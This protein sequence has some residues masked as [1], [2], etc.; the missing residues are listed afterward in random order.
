VTSGAA[1]EATK[2]IRALRAAHL[3]DEGRHALLQMTCE[4]IRSWGPPYTSVYAYMLDGAELVLE[5]HAGRETEHTR[6]PVGRGVCGTAV[7]EQRDQNVADVS[8]IGNYLACNLF[9]KSELVVLIRRGDHI[10]GQIDIDSDVPSGFGEREH[11]EVKEV[12]DALAVLL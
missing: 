12:A 3:H 8:A 1:S 7:A 4:R 9:T 11:A 5:A 2:V 10:L 6:I